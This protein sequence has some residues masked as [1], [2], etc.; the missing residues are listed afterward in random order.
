MSNMAQRFIT[1]TNEKHLN[2]ACYSHFNYF[3]LRER[4]KQT[5][6]SDGE[7]TRPVLSKFGNKQENVTSLN[8]VKCLKRRKG[9]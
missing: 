4:Q 6:Y 5:D 9:L 3:C 1:Y 2:T 8:T 7:F